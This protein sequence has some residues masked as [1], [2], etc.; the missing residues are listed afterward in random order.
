MRLSGTEA[1]D[2]LRKW[3]TEH[4]PVRALLES[5]PSSGNIRHAVKV[6]GFVNNFPNERL[7]SILISDTELGSLAD[8]DNLLL[9]VDAK[10]VQSFEYIEAKDLERSEADRKQ[11]A[12]LGG[13]SCLSIS[14]ESGYRIIIFAIEE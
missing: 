2:L 4:T 7:P 6:T 9:I 11:A 10:I 14:L 5:G 3:A 12:A 8:P 13:Q 1:S